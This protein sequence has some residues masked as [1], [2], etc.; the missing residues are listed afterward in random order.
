MSILL[1]ALLVFCTTTTTTTELRGTPAVQPYWAVGP[2][3]G[4]APPDGGR[5]ARWPWGL[6]ASR[7]VM[8][9]VSVVGGFAQL[10]FE[11]SRPRAALGVHAFVTALGFEL[12]IATEGPGDGRG[13]V[14]ALHLAPA[15]GF[16]L[17]TLSLRMSR[18]LHLGKGEV[19]APTTVAA[20]LALNLFNHPRH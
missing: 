3:G 11:G 16:A 8:T 9:N 1:G 12:G 6:E 17:G 5:R 14:A 4:Y 18:P 10:G 7:G 19:P 13:A 20:V 2:Y 15:L